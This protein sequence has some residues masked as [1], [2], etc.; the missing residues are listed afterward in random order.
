SG[1]LPAA[2]GL[3]LEAHLPSGLHRWHR[4]RTL[5]RACPAREL[6]VGRRRGLMSILERL[7][8]NL[9]RRRAQSQ[10]SRVAFPGSGGKPF[11]ALAAIVREYGSA[12]AGPTV[13]ILGDSVMER[14]SRDDTDTRPLGEMIKAALDRTALCI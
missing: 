12:G 7:R 9:T 14:V 2:A 5:H 6:V 8:A 13:L 11:P 10:E 4:R 3:P 1:V